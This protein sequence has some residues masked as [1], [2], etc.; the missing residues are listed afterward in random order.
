MKAEIIKAGAKIG[1][2]SFAEGS[3]SI[4]CDDAQL[5]DRIYLHLTS[6]E[7]KQDEEIK[8]LDAVKG[9]EPGTLEYFKATL[10]FIDEMEKEIEFKF[11]G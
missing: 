4:K 6:P 2:I 3:L 11:L 8:K 1:E 9:S 10:E 5:K 7:A